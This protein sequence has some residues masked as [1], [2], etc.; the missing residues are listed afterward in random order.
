MF[1]LSNF[2]PMKYILS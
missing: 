2:S 1:I